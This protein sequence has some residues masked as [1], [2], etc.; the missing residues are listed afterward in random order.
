MPGFEPAEK[1]S[2]LGLR[3]SCSGGFLSVSPCSEQLMSPAH[4]L[5]ESVVQF[6]A[7]VQRTPGL[8]VPMLGMPPPNRHDCLIAASMAERIAID[9]RN[10]AGDQIPVPALVPVAP[11]LAYGAAGFYAHPIVTCNRV[12]RRKGR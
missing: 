1:G 10:T 7:F 6:I 4:Q 5:L 8:N 9:A 3:I 2:G 12:R 11:V